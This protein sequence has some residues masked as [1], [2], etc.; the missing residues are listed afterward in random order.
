MGREDVLPLGD[1]Q[2]VEQRFCNGLTK[3]ET[4]LDLMINARETANAALQIAKEALHSVKSA[5]HR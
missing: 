4:K 2:T 5:H 3:V 1:N